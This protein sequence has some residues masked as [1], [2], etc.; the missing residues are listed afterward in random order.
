M[1]DKGWK[2]KEREG[3]GGQ[4][5]RAQ[6]VCVCSWSPSWNITSWVFLL[7]L[8]V[9]F[10]TFAWTWVFLVPPTP[11]DPGVRKGATDNELKPCFW[12]CLD[13]LPGIWQNPRRIICWR[14]PEER[15]KDGARGWWTFVCMF[16]HLLNSRSVSGIVLVFGNLKINALIYTFIPQS[17]LW[18]CDL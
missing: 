12:G 3:R 15:R 13:L 17:L 9:R 4:E 2:G 16:I 1:N 11:C 14:S 8:S 6:K 18:Y 7:T 5:G 10:T